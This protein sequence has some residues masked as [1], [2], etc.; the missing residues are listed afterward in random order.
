M[1]VEVL[2]RAVNDDVGA[3]LE[4]AL[5]KRRQ[6]RVVDRVWNPLGRRDT[7][8]RRDVCELQGRIRGGLS[9]N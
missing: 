5:I 1:A 2:G 9:Q 3:E 8:D 7:R 6:K 4:R